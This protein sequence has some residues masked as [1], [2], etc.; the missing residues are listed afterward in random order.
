LASPFF[1]SLKEEYAEFSEWYKKK[2]EAFAYVSEPR[3]KV[4]D[5][6]LYLKV[7]NGPIRDVTPQI[8]GEKILK[9]GTFKIDAHGTKLGERFVKKII[10]HAISEKIDTIYLTVFPEH[11]ELITLIIRYGFVKHGNK[12]TPNGTEQ[13]YIKR[14]HSITGDPVIDYPIINLTGH[15]PYLLSVWPIWHT[16]L[17]P[18]SILNTEDEDIIVKDISPTNSIHKIYL[19]SMEK[20]QVLKRGDTLL[21]YRTSDKQGPAYYRSVASSLCVVEEYKNINTFAV[22]EDFLN[23]CRPYSVFSEDELT[24]LWETK[25]YPYIIRFTYNIA[26]KR[27]INR[28]A[29]I[30]EIGLDA[31]AD[32][33]WGF[34]PLTVEQV[35]N[36]ARKG[37]I[38]ESLI[39]H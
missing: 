18:D 16:K 20:T 31:G 26:L 33:Y 14:L 17:L 28:K 34:M 6:F 35:M 37:E 27:K 30:E 21:I 13:V 19:C 10:D 8:D 39:V 22:K 12:E 7:E 24:K 9:V 25:K 38:D 3:P 1:D 32:S 15:R 29:L 11:P 36:I 4:I 5:G 2:A 23:Y